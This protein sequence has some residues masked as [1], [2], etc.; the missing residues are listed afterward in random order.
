MGFINRFLLFLYTLCVALLSL[1]VI[2]L[3][4]HMVPERNVWNEYQYLTAN[5]QTGAGALLFFLLS[6]H[7]LICSLSGGGKRDKFDKSS[8]IIIIN[9]DRG[10]V[11]VG[12]EAMRDMIKRIVGN[13]N[14]VRDVNVV[15]GMNRS[16]ENGDR[17]AVDVH[18]VVGQDRSVS[19]ISDD[20]RTKTG[21]CLEEIVGISE[22]DVAVSVDR[23][24]G[25][26]VQKKR[27]LM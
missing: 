6:V 25:G 14:G 19:A 11:Q 5:W 4:L 7:L 24:E 22:Y 1:G 16:A 17:M 21:N 13:V 15:C 20:I 27:R 9:G 23:I 10:N 8:D 26:V 18:I 3:V 2:A 12:I